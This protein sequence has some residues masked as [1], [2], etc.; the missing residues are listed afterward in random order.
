MKFNE[1]AIEEATRRCIEDEPWKTVYAEAPEG[2]KKRL[3]VA[4]WANCFRKEEED[5]DA[6]RIRRTEVERKEMTVE[7]AA[8]LA[9]KFPKGHAG[10]H[11]YRILRDKLILA[12][13]RT[14]AK[15]DDAMDAMAA[16]WSNTERMLFERSRTAYRNCEDSFGVYAYEELWKAVGGDGESCSLLGDM[17]N[18]GHEVDPDDELAVFWWRRGAMCNSEEC[19]LEL[20]KKLSRDGSAVHDMDEAIFWFMEGVRRNMLTVKRELGRLLAFGD[21]EWEKR[22]NPSLAF[23]LLWSCADADKTGYAYYYSGMCFEKG[24]GVDMSQETLTVCA[25]SSY[26]LA[27]GMG[28]KPAEKEYDRLVSENP[29]CDARGR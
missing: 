7:D 17:F 1:E 4:F 5:L 9:E 13:L 16:H 27:K 22:R 3:R 28:C 26:L 6:Y 24:I 8:Y 14:P 29:W 15:L 18:H 20:A 2:A 23:S 10:R 25:V 11:H 19:L 12:P 21:G